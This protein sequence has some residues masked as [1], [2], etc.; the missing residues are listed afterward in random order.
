MAALEWRP[1]IPSQHPRPVL[2]QEHEKDNARSIEVNTSGY[3]AVLRRRLHGAGITQFKSQPDDQGELHGRRHAEHGTAAVRNF[4]FITDDKIFATAGTTMVG[5]W[6]ESGGRCE[7]LARHADQFQPRT[8]PSTCGHAAKL[9]VGWST[10]PHVHQVFSVPSYR[11]TE[12]RR[13]AAQQLRHGQFALY[14]TSMPSLT[15]QQTT[16]TRPGADRP[17]IYGTGYVKKPHVQD[18]LKSARI[19]VSRELNGWFDSVAFGV[20]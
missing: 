2:H 12:A 4:Q 5:R 11:S 1:S 13:C 8:T 18:E 10:Q 20:N 15:F 16:P 9:H 19:D 3:R 6:L 7:L 14:G 17:T